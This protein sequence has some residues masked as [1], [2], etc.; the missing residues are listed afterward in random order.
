MTTGPKYRARI[1]TADAEVDGCLLLRGRV[2]RAGDAESDRDGF[3]ALFRHMLVE[4]AG[5]GR[6]VACF[7]FL[8]V[9]SP[10][11]IE[12]SYS[13]QF[14]GLSPLQT[15]GAP[16]VEMGR[17]CIDPEVRDSDVLRVAWGAMARVVEERGAGL[18]FGCSSFQ[19]TDA[20]RYNDAFAMLRDRHIAPKRWLPRI[21]APK[22]F[23]F[24]RRP[25]RKADPKAAIRAMPPLLKTYLAMGGWVSD[26]AVVDGDL[27]T[28]HV[29]TG[30]EI[31]T[32]PAARR[33]SILTA[34]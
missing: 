22:V 7:R 24:A 20:V 17:F 27:D 23:E 15:Y 21:K 16:M 30:V 29:F 34:A 32:I 14:Y 13:A 5:D 8:V 2:F 31:G 6:V 28:L 10:S 1:A 19:G 18:L 33:R 11:A 26:H 3:D 12:R 9:D 25:S 4:R